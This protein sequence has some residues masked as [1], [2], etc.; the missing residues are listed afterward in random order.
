[1]FVFYIIN[2]IFCCLLADPLY[3]FL[4]VSHRRI[5]CSL[6]GE[7]ADQAVNFFESHDMSKPAILIM[8]FGK[9]WKYMGISFYDFSVT[10]IDLHNRFINCLTRYLFRCDGCFELIFWNK[11]C[12]QRRLP[13]ICE[14]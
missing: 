12:D 5:H 4:C 8:Q 10:Y 11:S 2:E 3:H 6:W 1:M 14:L 7:F 13:G 9:T